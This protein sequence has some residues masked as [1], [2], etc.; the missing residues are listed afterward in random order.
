MSDEAPLAI[1]TITITAEVVEVAVFEEERVLHVAIILAVPFQGKQR[2]SLSSLC[3][4]SRLIQRMLLQRS[5]DGVRTH[6][7]AVVEVSLETHD[8]LNS[9]SKGGEI[10]A[11][12]ESDEL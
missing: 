4:G 1:S 6:G 10:I 5:T 11:R 2:P 12:A 3:I 8:K 9:I 7:G